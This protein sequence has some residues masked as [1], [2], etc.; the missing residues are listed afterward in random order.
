[1]PKNILYFSVV[2]VGGLEFANGGNLCCRN[3]IRRM[4]EDDGITLHVIIAGIAADREPICKFLD[5]LKL[6]YKFL[7]IKEAQSNAG[8]FPRPQFLSKL[9][10]GICYLFEESARENPQIEERLVE[11]CREWKIEHTIIDYLP[12]TLFCKSLLNSSRASII[13]LNREGEFYRDLRERGVVNKPGITGW[14]SQ[15]RWNHFEKWAYRRAARVVAIGEPDLPRIAGLQSE[16]RCVTPYLPQK[17]PGW[18]YSGSNSAFFV[19]NIHHYPN[20]LAMEWICTRLGPE[21]NLLRS[22]MRIEIVGADATDVPESWQTS[23]IKFAGISTAEHVQEL[24][25]NADICLCPIENDYGTKF[26]AAE[27][28][29][30]GTPLL[31]SKQTLLGFPYLKS[32]PHIELNAPIE[33]AKLLM[34]LAAR[35]EELLRMQSLQAD[36][37]NGFVA[38]Q[39]N[40]WSREVLTSSAA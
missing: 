9:R 32:F 35:K 38:T 17:E 40:V 10:G 26:K 14:L 1:M 24:F 20:R 37:H 11:S 39:K 7:E 23:N 12:S 21:L 3:H 28:L 5:E 31:A 22:D 13:T 27:A 15:Q 4:A 16:P 25:L 6:P 36:L 30:Y 19:G 2:N 29:A 18:Q 34:N 8:R 33:A